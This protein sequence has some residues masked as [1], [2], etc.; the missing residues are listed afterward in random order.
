MN[1]FEQYVSKYVESI[2]RVSESWYG[3]SSLIGIGRASDGKTEVFSGTYVTPLAA[4]VPNLVEGVTFIDAEVDGYEWT[5][6]VCFFSKIDLELILSAVNKDSNGVSEHK[7][8]F[9]LNENTIGFSGCFDG[10]ISKDDNDDM[11]N[12]EACFDDME[13]LIKVDGT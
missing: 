13:K 9:Y 1:A 4:M 10:Y 8:F 5:K 11:W 2:Y 7:S 12:I 3:A 6:V